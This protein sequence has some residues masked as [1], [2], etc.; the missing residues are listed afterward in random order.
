MNRAMRKMLVLVACVALVTGLAIGGTVA[1]LADSTEEVKNTFTPSNVGVELTES[2]ENYQM[3]P[4]QTIAKNPTITVNANSETSYVFVK[5]TRTENVDTFL[6]YEIA[7]GWE[8]LDGVDDVYWREVTEQTAD[9][10]FAVL[11]DNQVTV[12][13]TVTKEQMDNLT[14]ANYPK[15]TFKAFIIQK[16]GFDSE[17]AAWTQIGQE[18]W[19]AN[20]ANNTVPADSNN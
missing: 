7:D 3:I 15:L 8:Q 2:T 11:A 13:E 6:S 4:G 1:W 12:K 17:T 5:V 10:H 18:T 20:G 14:E 19:N 9:Q 16:A